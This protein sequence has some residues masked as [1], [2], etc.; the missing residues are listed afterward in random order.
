MTPQMKGISDQSTAAIQQKEC[1]LNAL[2]SYKELPADQQSYPA[3]NALSVALSSGKVDDFIFYAILT[4]EDPLL[5][6]RMTAAQLSTF[7]TFV[8]HLRTS[9]P[10]SVQ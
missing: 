4:R 9:P 7:A 6:N 3:L 10:P 1:L 5:F 8:L 2:I